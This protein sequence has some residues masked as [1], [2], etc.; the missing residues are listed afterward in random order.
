[1]Y[2]HMLVPIDGTEL[3]AEVVSRAI[4]FAHAIGARITFFHARPD[5]AADGDGALMYSIA[6]ETFQRNAMGEARGFLAKAE[7][8][9]RALGV[10]SDAVTQI[11][12]RPYEAIL[13][14]AEKEACDLIFMASH[15]TRGLKGMMVGSQTLKVLAGAKVPVLVSVSESNM[16]TP[17]Q[18][19]ATSVIKDEHRSIASVMHGLSYVV[20]EIREHELKPDFTMLKAMVS[21]LTT[22]PDKLH[23]PK[24]DT[25]LFPKIREYTRELDQTLDALGAQHREEKRLIEKLGQALSDYETGAS[26]AFD[27]FD[28]AVDQYAG[29]LWQHMATEEKLI[30]NAARK[31]LTESDWGEIAKAFGENGDS[32]FG[33]K[34]YQEY[35]SKF[36]DITNRNLFPL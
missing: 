23:H 36:A 14:A 33:E 9:A 2:H 4:E 1:M 32:R 8:A 3:S 24:E 7:A 30:M 13:E 22:F 34:M 10:A 29:F 26:G 20:S 15:G 5:N 35:R 28:E 18:L 6:P 27:Q 12:D 19:K 17:M 11:S 16:Q 25:Y 21:Y 31:H